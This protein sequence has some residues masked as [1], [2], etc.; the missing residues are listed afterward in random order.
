MV[1]SQRKTPA[2]RIAI[3]GG[4]VSG[5]ACSWTLR[6]HDFDVDIIEAGDKLGGHANSVPFE[7]N[8]RSVEVDT[9][10]VAFEEATYRK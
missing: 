6:E 1:S 8:G 3:V 5:I 10:F 9:G 7:G 4:G 2:K